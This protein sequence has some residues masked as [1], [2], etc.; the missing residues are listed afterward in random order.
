MLSTAGIGT[1]KIIIKD[2]G[3]CPKTIAVTATCLSLCD[4]TILFHK[5]CKNA[6]NKTAKNT[7]VLINFFGAVGET[8]TLTGNPHAP[9]ACLS[10]NFSTTALN[11]YATIN[12]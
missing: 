9:Q 12:E 3:T 7:T 8:R 6:A 2:A 1:K 11:L 4:L 10:T 5:A